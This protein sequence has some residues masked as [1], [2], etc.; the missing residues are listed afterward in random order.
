MNN[1]N[2]K[3]TKILIFPNLS[4]H[5]VTTSFTTSLFVKSPTTLTIFCYEF[6]I[7]E[8][9]RRYIFNL[10]LKFFEPDLWTLACMIE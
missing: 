9:K 6:N 8:I 4:I 10:V 5:L 7:K 2:F 1:N 3:L